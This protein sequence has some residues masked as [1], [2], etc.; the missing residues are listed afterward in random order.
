MISHDHH[1]ASNHRRQCCLFNILF[2]KINKVLHHWPFLGIHRSTVESSHKEPVMRKMFPC[3]VVLMHCTTDVLK[4]LPTAHA[5][6]CADATLHSWRRRITQPKHLLIKYWYGSDLLFIQLH[7][8]RLLQ[9]CSNSIA[10]A[11]ELLQSCTKSLTNALVNVNSYDG[12][13]GIFR[14]WGSTPCLLMHW[15]LKSSGRQ[16]TWYWQ[17]MIGSM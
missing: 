6:I 3:Y 4:R 12:G 15:L 9:D 14:L 16:Q 2:L 5:N 13:D 7:I 11:L 17:N 1:G 10:N 8:H